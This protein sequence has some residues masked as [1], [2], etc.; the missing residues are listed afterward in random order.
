MFETIFYSDNMLINIFVMLDMYWMYF[1]ALFVPA[2]Y[3]IFLKI[4]TFPLI[5]RKS[6]EFVIMASPESAKIKKIT[7]RIEPFFSFKKGLYW[8]SESS[9]D[10]GSLNRYSVYLEGINQNILETARNK[11]KVHD[12]LHVA[13]LPRQVSS[14]KI[15][16]PT[17]VREHF[18]RHWKFTLNAESLKVR[19]E[20]TTERQPLRV[21]F[22]HTFGIY[23]EVPEQVEKPIEVDGAISSAGLVQVQ[24]TTQ[25]IMRQLK[26]YAENR[27]FSSSYM[28]HTWKLALAAP[29]SIVGRLMGAIDPR[30]LGILVVLIAV[31]GAV[32]AFMYFSNPTVAL[33]PMPK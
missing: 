5:T 8:F 28:Y 22:Y 33:G 21:S 32:G 23:L 9:E 14:H 31:L 13:S 30:M 24:I 19:I 27:N 7:S 15:L 18:S 25:L 6:H 10:Q 20:P 29:Q 16:L 12:I 26:M 4:F 2:S 3:Y 1:T 11:N 17:R